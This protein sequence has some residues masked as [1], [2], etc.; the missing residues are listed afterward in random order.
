MTI[1]CEYENCTRKAEYMC[2]DCG[3]NYC[4]I[5]AEDNDFDCECYDVPRL[6]PL[7]KGKKCVNDKR[8]TGKSAGVEG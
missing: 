3:M 4:R 8:I 5:C 6:I 2:E 1:K 7:H